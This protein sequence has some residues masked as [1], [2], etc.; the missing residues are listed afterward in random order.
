M[1]VCVCVYI[2][3]RERE[4]ERNKEDSEFFSPSTVQAEV[5]KCSDGVELEA[6][7]LWLWASY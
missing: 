5:I 7:F 6:V 3:E 4:R 1:W 2:R